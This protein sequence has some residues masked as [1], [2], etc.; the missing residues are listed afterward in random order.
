MKIIY[1]W[2]MYEKK[3]PKLALRMRAGQK[4]RSPTGMQQALKLEQTSK[5]VHSVYPDLHID[6]LQSAGSEK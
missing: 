2:N 5:P 6:H 3:S 4:R 1:I